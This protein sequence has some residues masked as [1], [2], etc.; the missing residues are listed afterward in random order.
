MAAG[1]LIQFRLTEE[2]IQ[3]LNAYMGNGTELESDSLKAKKALITLITGSNHDS[4]QSNHDSNQSSN[5]SSNH[6]NQA[7]EEIETK[8]YQRLSQQI[9]DLVET[10]LGE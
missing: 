4:N 6:S 10:R 9:N 1:K 8:L 2:E 7:L 3:A 5:H